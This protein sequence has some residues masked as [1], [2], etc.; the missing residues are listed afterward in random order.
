MLN[1]L[2]GIDW[3][4]HFILVFLLHA[5]LNVWFALF[6]F[7][8]LL[9]CFVL[10]TLLLGNFAFT[11]CWFYSHVSFVSLNIKCKRQ[12]LPAKVTRQLKIYCVVKIRSSEPK[13]WWKLS[14]LS[15]K[16]CVNSFGHSHCVDLIMTESAQYRFTFI[17]SFSCKKMNPQ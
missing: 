15:K 3:L 12:L 4:P 17:I 7:V 8:L 13:Y 1:H 6:C 5:K 9:C 14:G 11:M 2:M 16:C 10:S